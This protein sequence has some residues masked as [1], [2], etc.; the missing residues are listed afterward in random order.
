MQTI[1]RWMCIVCVTVF[2]YVE[3]AFQHE[4]SICALFQNDAKW[5]PEWIDFH[6]K[7]GVSHFWLICCVVI[8]VAFISSHKGKFSKKSRFYTT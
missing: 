5:L 8:Y 6:Q 3:A 2:L 1:W 7:Q 4:L